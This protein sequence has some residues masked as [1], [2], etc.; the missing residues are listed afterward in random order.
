MAV[1]AAARTSRAETRSWEARPRA[2]LLTRLALLALPILVAVVAA[3]AV[4]RVVDR[5]TGAGP[6]LLWFGLLFTVAAGVL[7]LVERAARRLLPIASLLELT[8]VF[9]DRTPSRFAVALRAGLL[10]RPDRR[11]QQLVDAP[12]EEA[13]ETV[14]AL[15]MSLGA[16]DRRTQGHSERVR[17]YAEVIADE[18][19]LGADERN[20]LRWSALLHDIGKLAVHPHV[21]QK[22]EALHDHEWEQIRRHPEEGARLVSTLVPW[23]GEW[24]DVVAQHH[25]R[26]DGGGYPAG[27]AG[28]EISLGGRIVAVA[29]AFEVMTAGRSYA[30]A[31]GSPAAREELLRCAGSQFDPAMVRAFLNAGIAPVGWAARAAAWLGA[32]TF[33]GRQP[34]RDLGTRVGSAV[35]AGVVVA[36]LASPVPS[37][38]A[39]VVE[40]AAEAAGEAA[41]EVAGVSVDRSSTDEVAAPAP[42]AAT[43]VEPAG[44]EPAVP[45][46]P[47]PVAPVDAV[48]PVPAPS[49]AVAETLVAPAPAPV[50][51]PSPVAAEAPAPPAPEPAPAPPPEAPTPVPP[52]P[53]E[54][55]PPP[56]PTRFAQDDQAATA[57]R[58]LQLTPL[59]NDGADGVTIDPAT[60][61]I[62]DPPDHANGRPGGTGDGV[63]AY[64]PDPRFVG[65]DSMTYRVCTTAGV[66]ETATVLITVT[67]R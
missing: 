47:A 25:E 53:T 39:P 56:A 57:G 7:L 44:P 16:H 59:A 8:L 40:S 3:L 31:I 33:A 37:V 63:I 32:L 23:L 4:G 45:V 2:A 50:P 38:S 48:G 29:D 65:V 22:D 28:A 55:P 10:V 35:A 42:E 12:R 46:A 11:V 1:V 64:V 43:P 9:P 17:A 30:G 13:V 58:P 21:L 18:L 6:V 52:A 19:R 14:L 67:E 41:A 5:P 34:G 27:L 54:P 61:E 15:V 66:C 51:E 49:P 62:L 60:F 36:L 24:A 26:W 20:R